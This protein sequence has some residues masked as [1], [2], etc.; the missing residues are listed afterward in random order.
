[1]GDTATHEVR[2]A[3]DDEEMPENGGAASGGDAVE[4]QLP[5]VAVGDGAT[6]MQVEMYLEFVNY[7][8]R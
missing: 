5:D 7:Q 2:G 6:L 1:M 3:N 4:H 8:R